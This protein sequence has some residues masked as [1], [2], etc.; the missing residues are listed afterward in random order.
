MRVLI[1]LLGTSLGLALGCTP[2]PPTI[3]M[4]DVS[5]MWPLPATREEGGFLRA[6]DTGAHGTLLPR[7]IFDTLEALTRFDEPDALY[8]NLTVVGARLDP[9]LME[10]GAAAPCRP[11]LRLVVQPVLAAPAGSGRR[12]LEARDAALHLFYEPTDEAEVLSAIEALAEARQAAGHVG[13][14]PLDVHPLLAEVDTRGVVLDIL[15]PLLG[16]T[17][18]SRVTEVS[19]HGDDAAWTFSGIDRVDDNWTSMVLPMTGDHDEQHVL[20]DGGLGPIRANMTPGSESPDSFQLLLDDSAARAASR[21]E[22][23][24]AFDA[25]ARVENPNFHDP[26]TIDCASC[27]LAAVARQAALERDDL[28]SSPDAYVSDT[29]DLTASPIFANTQV[30]R[31]FG[32]RHDARAIAP[33]TVHESAAVAERVNVLLHTP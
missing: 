25:A 10:G 22:L 21:A 32:Y 20:S 5:L 19:V 12:G 11:S 2:T 9:C 24:D 4:V 30:I 1:W 18:L 6:P 33:R 3:E 14:G 26:G 7:A 15:R 23:Q 31:A 29:H 28:E 13:D 27:H 8:E 17:R 16:E